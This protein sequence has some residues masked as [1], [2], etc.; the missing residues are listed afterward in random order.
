MGRGSGSGAVLI[1][2]AWARRPA[3]G[4]D[5]VLQTGRGA[6]VPVSRKETGLVEK[7]CAHRPPVRLSLV[8]TFPAPAAAGGT[9]L[10]RV[11]PVGPNN[12]GGRG[13]GPHSRSAR[14]DPPRP[15]T[16]DL[17]RPQLRNPPPPPWVFLLPCQG[18]EGK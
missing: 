17:R 2:P 3:R 9:G 7:A 11:G 1:G 6:H 14:A 5:G 16:G 4:D 10:P 18:S 15:P 8:P 13:R 12:R